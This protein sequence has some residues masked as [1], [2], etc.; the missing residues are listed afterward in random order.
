MFW[1]KPKT[2]QDPDLGLLTHH[3]KP[4]DYW[5]SQSIATSAGD[6]LI[7]L[8]GDSH[9]PSAAALAIAKQALLQPNPLVVSA[10]SYVH[11]SA[12]AREFI[13][14]HGELA[15]DGFSFTDTPGS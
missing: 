7:D 2:F 12:S 5:L 8:P 10:M 4:R 1:R 13:E 6:V 14:G 15:L 9:T 3:H 11:A